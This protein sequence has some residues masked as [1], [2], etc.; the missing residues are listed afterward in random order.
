MKVVLASTTE[1]YLGAAKAAYRLHH[2]L[3]KIGVDSKM[4]VRNRWSGE[5]DIYT[6]KK[7]KEKIY[8]KIILPYLDNLPLKMYRKRDTDVFSCSVFPSSSLNN[9]R[10]INPDL[11]N[12]HWVQSGFVSVQSLRKNRVPVVLTLH[13]MWAFTGGCHYSGE[14]DKYIKN[15]GKCPRLG[16]EMKY[17]LSHYIYKRK[18][19]AY[20]KVKLYIVSPSKWL[21]NIAKES[22]LFKN[23]VIRIIPNGIDLSCYKPTNKRIARGILGIPKDKKIILFA[24]VGGAKDPRKGFA[25][26]EKALIDYYESCEKK[27]RDNIELIVIGETGNKELNKFPIQINYRGKIFD[28]VSLALHYSAADIFIT[29]SLQDNLP[30]TVMES[31][32]CG[33]PVLGF[34]TGGI[35]DMVIHKKNGYLAKCFDSND[36]ANG[37]K[38]LLEDG[39]RLMEMSNFSANDASQ[40][41]DQKLSAN[42]YKEFYEEIINRKNITL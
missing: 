38:W 23:S 20:E 4:F 22:S 26:L 13:D 6:Q 42:R 18:E 35:P 1:S 16:S 8:Q 40:K 9:I 30:N 11:I 14:C 37:V 3:L 32:A 10:A 31:L 33:T 39:V 29:P 41:Y 12:L 24:A 28:E 34:S 2:G 36:L 5:N 7:P 27:E 21:G 17:D 19:K 15:C 25:I